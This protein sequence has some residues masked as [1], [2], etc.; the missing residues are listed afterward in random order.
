MPAGSLEG[1]TRALLK[2]QDGCQNFC[3]YC[4]IPFARG[5]SRSLPLDQAVYEVKRL[6]S[7]N[8]RE[9]V[10]TG[11]EI[12]SWGADLVPKQG[13]ADLLEALC[14][15]APNVRI[16]L[17][18]LE[19]RTVTEDFARRVS[20]FPNLCPHFH[21]SM[22]SGCDKTLKAMNRKYDTARYYESCR[23]LRQYFPGCAITQSTN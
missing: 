17:G 20:R 9:I 8:Y 12:S 19:P 6:A 22:Q 18:S 23:L 14:A 13:L 21:L 1:R 10:I 4:I 2:V 11:I 3:T 16:R 7:E 15:A 5:P